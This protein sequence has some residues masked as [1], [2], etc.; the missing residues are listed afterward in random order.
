MWPF[1]DIGVLK[2]WKTSICQE[3]WRDPGIRGSQ[4]SVEDWDAAL[5][6]CNFATSHFSCRKECFYHL[7][8]LLSPFNFA[9]HETDDPFATP[10]LW[11][12]PNAT[13]Y[14][15]RAK[16][17]FCATSKM[18]ENWWSVGGR[19]ASCLTEGSFAASVVAVVLMGRVDCESASFVLCGHCR[20]ISL[21]LDIV[22]ERMFSKRNS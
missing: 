17:D 22:L 15:N 9:T 11:R 2:P 14:R 13:L 1:P 6:S 7:S 5:S 4:S 18:I 3:T 10:Y 19:R 8:E 12:Q 16:I 20:E 21:G